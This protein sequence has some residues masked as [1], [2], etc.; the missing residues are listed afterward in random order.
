MTGNMVTLVKLNR[1]HVDDAADTL[2]SAFRDYPLNRYFYQDDAEREHMTVS[3]FRSVVKRSVLYGEAFSTSDYMEGVALWLPSRYLEM[4]LW[5]RLRC[6][7]IGKQMKE[8]RGARERVKTFYNFTHRLHRQLIAV[9]HM[10]LWVIGV[11]PDYQGNGLSSQL[12]KPML[13]RFD[14][15]KL[16]CFVETHDEKNVPLY[17]HFGFRIVNE[18]IIPGTTLKHW[19]LMREPASRLT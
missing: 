2:V 13:S 1:T 15:Q 14:D 8:N 12:I 11:M 7:D 3:R 17:R 9:E 6:G 18:S 4:S 16:A 10:F 5:Q 19:A